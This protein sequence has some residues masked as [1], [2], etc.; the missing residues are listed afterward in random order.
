MA[1]QEEDARL[2]EEA[3]VAAA[4]SGCA[5]FQ[6][7]TLRLGGRAAGRQATVFFLDGL[8]SEDAVARDVIRPLTAPGRLVG[9]RRR[10]AFS[11]ALLEGGA[12][13]ASA[14]PCEGAEAAERA[15]LDGAC[16][17]FF[18][19][20]AAAALE[21]RGKNVRAVDA[22]KEEKVVK[23]SR[24]AFVETLRTNTALVRR[25]LRSA[26]LRL[27]ETTLG[28][29]TATRV[30]LVWL[31]GYTAPALVEEVRRRLSAVRAEGLLNAAVLE[32]Q[33]SD[34]PESPF[35]QLLTTERPDKFCE[36]L[37]EGRVGVLADGLPMGFLA[38][39][40]FVQFFKVPED[41]SS[42]YLAASVITALRYLAV[43]VTLL[44]PGFYVAAVTYHQELLPTKLMLTIIEARQ[45]VPF[46]TAVEVLGMLV[47]FELL[48]EAGLRMPTPAGQT[49]SI[50]G[51]L[52]VGQSAVEAKVISPLVVIVV[53][54]AGVA[55]YTVPSPDMAAAL[56]I[57]RFVLVAASVA[58]GFFGLVTG[59]FLLVWELSS[60]DSFG[61]AYLAP[62][63]EGRGLLRAL[64]RPPRISR[65]PREPDLAPGKDRT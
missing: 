58:A 25:K 57:W 6:R 28:A 42:H 21:T 23:G 16:A 63:T 32:E 24:D 51:A 40:T 62:F 22:P 48:Q 55:G 33:L 26:D 37:L 36:N 17:V 13:C 20:E 1:R 7:R 5:D 53:A 46:P 47:A 65:D 8:V 61:V 31:K 39:G 12:W 10:E 35:P 41:L 29:R 4:F 3:Q 43:A 44:L 49:I 54:M 15:L 2:T 52:V 59:T 64:T 30:C 14:R 60:M 27:E 50:V 34:R 56:R 45:S 19:G 18:E 11:A 9:I 38:P